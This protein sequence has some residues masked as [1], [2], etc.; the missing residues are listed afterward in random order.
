MLCLPNYYYFLVFLNNNKLLF[1]FQQ[2]FLILVQPELHSKND[3][4]LFLGITIPFVLW[5]V[6]NVA[7]VYSFFY[8]L[9]A[10]SIFVAVLQPLCYAVALSMSFRWV[11]LVKARQNV[12]RFNLK[13]LSLEEFTFLLFWAT[14]MIYTPLPTLYNLITGD[15][16]WKTRTEGNLIFLMCIHA[17]FGALLIG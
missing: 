16:Y 10:L 3:G 17:L 5:F 11:W 6:A 2:T 8:D 4:I 15:L 12:G 14:A 1:H 9:Q 13:L 7:Y